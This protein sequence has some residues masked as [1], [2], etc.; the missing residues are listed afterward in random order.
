MGVHYLES[1]KFALHAAMDLD[2]LLSFQPLGKHSLEERDESRPSKTS[3]AEGN[4]LSDQEKLLLLQ[5]ID[6]DDEEPCKCVCVLLL[7]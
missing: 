2:E 5:N 6:D 7:I 3:K 1:V 4:G